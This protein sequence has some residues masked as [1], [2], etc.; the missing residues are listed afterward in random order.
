[1][2]DFFLN[3]LLPKFADTCTKKNFPK[4]KKKQQHSKTNSFFIVF[5]IKADVIIISP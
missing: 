5:K 2:Y 3:Y 1:M 4:K